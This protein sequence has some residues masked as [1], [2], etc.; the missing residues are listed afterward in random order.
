MSAKTP[1]ARGPSRDPTRRQEGKRRGSLEALIREASTDC[2]GD[3]DCEFHGFVAG[4]E[5]RV[6]FPFAAQVLGEEVSILGV[7]AARSHLRVGVIMSALKGGRTY[8]VGLAGLELPLN[9]PGRERVEAYF[10]W[11]HLPP[12][13]APAAAPRPRFTPRQGHYLAYIAQYTRVH[14]RPPAENEI[15][16]YFGVTGPAAHTMVVSLA[17]RGLVERSPGVPRSIRLLVPSSELPELAGPA[18][19]GAAGPPPHGPARRRKW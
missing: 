6:A 3:E 9:L 19:P 12:P 5:D 18:D 1:G 14:G 15:A 17:A 16:R 7:D 11:A 4:I 2:Y 8:P 10:E 13:K